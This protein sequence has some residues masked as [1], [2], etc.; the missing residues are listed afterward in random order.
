MRLVNKDMAK[1]FRDK[2]VRHLSR[3]CHPDVFRQRWG[4]LGAM[5]GLSAKQRLQLVCLVA[6][7]GDL[8]NLEIAFEVAGCAPM[9]AMME[10]AAAA[11]QLYSC[12]WL[13][14]RPRECPWGNALAKAAQAGHEDVVKGLLHEGCPR[15]D[16]AVYAAASGG[17]AH[18][19]DYLT[20][21]NGGTVR[22]GK[23]LA[24]AA[25]GCDLDAFQQLHEKWRRGFPLK[26]LGKGLS[27]SSEINIISA[28]AGSPLP[29]WRAK[30]EWLVARG[31][32]VNKSQMGFAA[33]RRPDG[34]NRLT[35]LRK[36]GYFAGDDSPP[37]E[38][39]FE[40]AGRDG[41]I[42]VVLYL[43]HS[44]RL[45]HRPRY[46]E[47][48]AVAAAGAGH[49]GFLVTLREEYGLEPETIKSALRSAARAGQ[50]RVLSWAEAALPG[51]EVRSDPELLTA[52]AESGNMELVEWV[53]AR[54]TSRSPDCFLGAVKGGCEEVLEW[55][56]EHGFLASAGDWTAYYLA[57]GRNGDLRTLRW[58]HGRLPPG[59]LPMSLS[60]RFLQSKCPL[61]TI[62]WLVEE[63][64]CPR[65]WSVVGLT[66]SSPGV[67]AWL[68]SVALTFSSSGSG[69]T[70]LSRSAA[71][72]SH[73]IDTGN[74]ARSSVAEAA[75]A[76]LDSSG[77]RVR[78]A[79]CEGRYRYSTV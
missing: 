7:S 57:A 43:L 2:V 26:L 75:A 16:D 71:G 74:G 77:A 68:G 10:A 49:V 52:A 51:Y 38:Q 39:T 4:A 8:A 35:W 65:D 58:L 3:P 34:L 55:M 67:H 22:V 70:T 45:Q 60:S 48:A 19:I 37:W 56:E 9:E 61:E 66:A 46:M 11:G 15:S 20:S 78:G 33:A 42:D 64:G 54:S 62:R 40:A 63:A 41:N 17:H 32:P 25:E 29:D 79:G 69:V 73:T 1:Y 36:G 59:P 6:A 47:V 44:Y 23:L 53:W 21:N 12:K 27:T 18:L 24:A 31:Y 14:S 13:R 50:L 5:T 30:V 76:A 28:A 72:T